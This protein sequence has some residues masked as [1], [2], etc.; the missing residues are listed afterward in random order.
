MLRH[1]PNSIKQRLIVGVALFLLLVLAITATVTYI[2]FKQQIRE[3]AMAQQF[4]SLTHVARALDDKLLSA[5]RALISVAQVLPHKVLRDPDAAQVWL[6]NRAGVSSFFNNGLFI[7]RP[8]GRLLVENPHLPGR[9]G[10]DASFREYYLRTLET[11]KPYISKPY[12]SSKHGHPTVMLTAP[13]FDERQRLVAILGGAIDLLADGSLFMDL[14]RARYGHTGYFFLYAQDRTMILHPD[15]S[16]IM[17]QDVPPGANR[18]YDQAL[19]GWE[20]SGETVTSRG[21]HAI[22]SFQR[23]TV[24]DWIVGA[25]LPAAEAYEPVSR[26][27]LFYLLGMG[28]ALLLGIGG[29]WWLGRSITNGLTRLTERIATLEPS[30]LTYID[31]PEAGSSYE[32]Q[33]LTATFNSLISQVEEARAQLRQSNTEIASHRD[34]LEAVVESRTA[35]LVEARATAEAASRSKGAFLANMSHEIRTPLNVI[36]GLVHLLR[37]EASPVQ[38]ERLDKV[39]IAGKHLLSI[40]NS[41]LDISKIEAGKLQLEQGNFP[42]SAVLDHVHS[43][44]SDAARAKGLAF[45]VD[46]DAVPLWLCGDVMRLRQCLLNFA[47]NALKFTERGHITLAAKLLEEREDDLLVRFSVTDSGP[48]IAAEKLAGLFQPFSQADNSTTR[49]YGGTGLGLAITR[50]LAEMMGGE[51]GADS[52][53]GQGSTFWFTARLKRGQAILA[54]IDG[55]DDAAHQLRARGEQARVLLAEDHPVNQEIAFELLRAV[56]LSVDVVGDGAEALEFARRQHYHLVLMDIQ[57]PNM[58]GLDACRAIRALPGWQDIP[59]VAMTA[60]A[61]EEDRQATVLAGMND[62]IAKPVDPEQL[63]A[64]LCKWLPVVQKSE[65]GDGRGEVQV[66]GEEEALTT[67]LAEI[68]DLE[69]AAG[70]RLARGKVAFYRRLLEVFVEAHCNDAQELT[71]LIGQKQLDAAERVA[72][73]LKGAAG[74]VGAV[75]IFLLATLLDT[76]LKQGD[77]ARAEIDLALLAERLTRLIDALRAALR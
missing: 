38:I 19:E 29:I 6:D 1:N 22:S 48:G 14:V 11:G 21:L 60:N 24:N 2:Y 76:S 34:Q 4:T 39:S 27:R 75:P 5:H 70:L 53:P 42:L 3:Q 46:P 30:Q 57:M 49:Q 67:R 77:R 31:F 16:R 23:L 28:L 68:P 58:D 66:S 71:R 35:E 32:V 9:R 65:T 36:L 50:R 63:Y 12:A 25:N 10:F 13:I 37:G 47:G 45:H 44:L 73:R 52:I 33:K 62:H 17:K 43:M 74:N 54:Q 51:A 72:H 26:F 15:S 20:G 41:I 55:A 59:I 64:K 69:L 18:L 61:F 7:F 40:I 56:K 8:D